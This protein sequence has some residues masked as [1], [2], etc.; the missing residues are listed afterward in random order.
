MPDGAFYVF[1]DVSAVYGRRYKGKPIVGSSAF[2][3]Y[4]LDEWKIAIIPGAGFGADAYMRLSYATSMA[5]IEK[6]LDRFEAG[7]KALE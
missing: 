2:C 7:L 3:D 5:N 1:P 6:G 4:M